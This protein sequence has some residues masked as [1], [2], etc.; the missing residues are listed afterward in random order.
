MFLLKS[1]SN[2]EVRIWAVYFAI[3]ECLIS[4]PIA[5]F[6]TL[7]IT[8]NMALIINIFVLVSELALYMFT[9]LFIALASAAEEWNLRAVL[10]AEFEFFWLRLTAMRFTGFGINRGGE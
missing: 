9:P 4:F 10:D 5:N 8:V 2:E 6:L 7:L 3:L 1:V